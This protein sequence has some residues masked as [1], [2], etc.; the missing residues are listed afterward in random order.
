[1]NATLWLALTVACC[2][3]GCASTAS[4]PANH[5]AEAPAGCVTHT[6]NRIPDSSGCTGIG[7]SYSQSDITN[8][9]QTTVAG[10]L[11]QLDPSVTIRR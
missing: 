11:G 9:G 8:T 3:G 6:G 7:S 10:A 2:I 4:A 1:M 5:R